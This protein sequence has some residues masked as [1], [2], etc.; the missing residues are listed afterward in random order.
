[1]KIL[2]LDIDVSEI[3]RAIKTGGHYYNRKWSYA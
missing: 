3:N 1:M 2:L